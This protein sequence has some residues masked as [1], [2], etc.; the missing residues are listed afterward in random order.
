[1]PD[2]PIASS[3]DIVG[4]WDAM[5][6]ADADRFGRDILDAETRW[7]WCSALL[8]G[9]LPYLWQQVAYIPRDLALDR[10]ELF[11]GDRVL[12]FGEAVTDIGFDRL[13]RDRVGST[14][15]VEVIDIRHRVLDTMRAGKPPQWQWTETSGVPNESFDCVLVGQAV[16]HAADWAREGAELLRIMKP[17][18]RLVLAEIAFSDTFYART[19]ADVHLEYWLRKMLE[20]MGQSLDS[21]VRWNQPE[22]TAALG[23]QLEGMETFE[24]RGVELL[25]G[26]KPVSR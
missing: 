12:I 7:R 24:W 20:G 22:L 26:R 25:W 3:D 19:H 6:P 10:L 18:R 15:T 4:V 11:P 13:I 9:G 8:V 2:H 23:S 21:L 1:M 17:G 5:V 14:G 16:A